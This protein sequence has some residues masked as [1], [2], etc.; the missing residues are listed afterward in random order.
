MHYIDRKAFMSSSLV[1]FL[2]IMLALSAAS[3]LSQA[4]QTV[5]PVATT[6]NFTIN[7]SVEEVVLHATVKNRKGA[8]V[9]GLA[10]TDFQVFENG[11]MQSIKHFSHED[12]PVTVGLVIDNSGSMRP[13]RAEVI[14]A[15]LAFVSSSNPSDQMFLVNFN[16]HVSFGLPAKTP[17]TD[18]PDQL[19]SAMG[20]VISNG[21]TALYDAVAIA[22]EHL[23]KGTLDKKVLIV[24]S[25]GADNASSRSR[26]QMLALAA[27]SNAIIYA[28]GIYTPEDPDKDPHVLNELADKSGGHAYFPEELRDVRPICERIAHE[29]RNQY[30]LSYIPQNQNQ[31]GSYRAIQVRAAFPGAHGLSVTTRVGYTAP[32]KASSSENSTKPV[33]RN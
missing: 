22:L 13:K 20:T 21:K 17:F 19:K 15:T 26:Q 33:A 10:I 2:S 3:T 1:N 14:A 7:V 23:N 6:P 27:H 4:Q 11:V 28:L 29:I 5:P 12:V 30:T 8:P 31:D 32:L 18:N 25:D 16:E 24:V 9:S